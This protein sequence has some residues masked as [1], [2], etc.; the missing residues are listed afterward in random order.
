MDFK[1]TS[2]VQKRAFYRVL[3]GILALSV[4]PRVSL[5][6]DLSDGSIYS[7]FGIGQRTHYS[8]ARSL[9]MGGG[10][11]GLASTRYTNFSN[12]AGFADRFLPGSR[13]DSRMKGSKN[14]RILRS[15]VTLPPAI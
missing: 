3:F 11:I 9:A 8:S 4:L 12:P 15:P 1:S 13:V 2:N 5:S 14:R 6:Q 10:G 7:R